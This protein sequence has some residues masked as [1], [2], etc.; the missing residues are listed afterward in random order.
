MKKTNFVVIFW[1]IL[2]L[3]GFILFIY[4]FSDLWNSIGYLL[5]PEEDYYRTDK[6]LL[7]DIIQ[8][9][10]MAILGVTI[11]FVAFKQG[12]NHYKE[13]INSADA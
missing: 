6:D 13:Q 1:L 9:L 4:N 11:F 2:S 12:I 5:I 7:R 3:V 8:D 10:P